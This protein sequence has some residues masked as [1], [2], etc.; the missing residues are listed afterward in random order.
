MSSYSNIENEYNQQEEEKYE[1]FRDWKERHDREK[2]ILPEGYPIGE[3]LH[4]KTVKSYAKLGLDT[5]DSVYYASRR[6]TERMKKMLTSLAA[7]RGE[8]FEVKKTITRVYRLK[9]K[10]NG[11]EF[12]AWNE[13]LSFTDKMDNPH[14]ID[15]SRCGTHEEAVGNIRKDINGRLLGGEVTGIKVVFD[16]AWSPKE[17]ESLMKQ[18]QGE[19]KQTEFMIGFTKNHGKNSLY[20]E[21][22]KLRSIK[23]AED[24]KVGKFEELWELSRRALSG[25][26]P[27][28]SRLK[29]PISQDG[30]NSLAKQE[31]FY[32]NPNAIS[33]V[34]ETY[35]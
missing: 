1:E 26:E 16:T 31:R 7:E 10:D 28:L 25:T 2:G 29:Q 21:G 9:N 8:K 11:K 4:P 5:P 34:Q 22:D 30:A 23:C 33:Y 12:L 32:V 19:S 14:S 13:I 3:T 27:S 6:A 24:F 35:Q 17:F 15:Y 20:S 18:H